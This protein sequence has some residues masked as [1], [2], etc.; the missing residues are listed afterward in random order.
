MH[1]K[2]SF[3]FFLHIPSLNFGKSFSLQIPKF[4][5]ALGQFW[6]RGPPIFGIGWTK[7]GRGR[8]GLWL[9]YTIPRNT[10]TV[11]AKFQLSSWSRSGITLLS[12]VGVGGIPYISNSKIWNQ[13]IHWILRLNLQLFERIETLGEVSISTYSSRK[14]K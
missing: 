14:R 8:T 2:N 7:S 5:W 6:Y 11:C 4:F 1:W 3:R 10:L 13:Y 12:W 9:P